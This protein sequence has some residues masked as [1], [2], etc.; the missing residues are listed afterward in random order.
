MLPV[1]GV[2]YQRLKSFLR[3]T[4]SCPLLKLKMKCSRR[5]WKRSSTQRMNAP[6]GVARLIISSL[7]F[8]LNCRLCWWNNKS[9]PLWAALFS[10]N[11]RTIIFVGCANKNATCKQVLR[12]PRGERVPVAH[13]L[14]TDRVGRR[15]RAAFCKKPPAPRKNFIRDGLRRCDG[16]FR[17]AP[18]S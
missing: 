13:K 8:S 3:F 18:H 15:D 7:S 4:P 5:C 14:R 16:Y 12:S 11:L 1:V 2:S 10:D 17:T 6:A 9:R